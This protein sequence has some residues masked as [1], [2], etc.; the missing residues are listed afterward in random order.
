MD[1]LP[2]HHYDGAIL[3]APKAQEGYFARYRKDHPDESFDVLTLGELEAMFQY[4]LDSKADDTL[5]SFGVDEQDIKLAKTIIRR[6][7][8]APRIDALSSYLEMK[9]ELEKKGLL[10]IKSDPFAYFKGKMIIVRG[11]ADGRA[12]SEAMQDLPNICVNFDFGQERPRVDAPKTASLDEAEG[13]IQEA[14]KPTYLLAGS[15]I[16]NRLLNLPRL[17]EPYA[18]SEG[19]IVAVSSAQPYFVAK[20]MPLPEEI[21]KALRLPSE[22]EAERRLEVEMASLLACPRLLAYVRF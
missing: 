7:R 12:I 2:S 10:R 13:L 14:P 19:S 17:T 1:I 5:L 6:L 3:I 15:S 9:D 22:K 18:P 8:Y 11:Y 16:P 21:L 20:A 4:E